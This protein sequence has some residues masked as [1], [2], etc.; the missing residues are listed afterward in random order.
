MRPSP[1]IENA[2]ADCPAVCK[3]EELPATLDYVRGTVLSYCAAC[4]RIKECPA[5]PKLLQ[6]YGKR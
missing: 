4:E 3:L 2:V 1:T 5:P 6:E